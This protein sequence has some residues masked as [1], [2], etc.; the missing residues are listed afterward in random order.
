MRAAAAFGAVVRLLG[1]GL[2]KLAELREA[3]ERILGVTAPVRA[4][5]AFGAVVWLLGCGL[6]K[7]AE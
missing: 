4:A 6:L 3:A 7:L 5:A 1:C 2:P